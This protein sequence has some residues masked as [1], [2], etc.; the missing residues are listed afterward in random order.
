[1]GCLTIDKLYREALELSFE[2]TDE[3]EEEERLSRLHYKFLRRIVRWSAEYGTIQYGDMRLHT[4]L[5]MQCWSMAVKYK[6]SLQKMKDEEFDDVTVMQEITAEAMIH[7]A[8]AEDTKQII[9]ILKTLDAPT[10]KQLSMGRNGGSACQRDCLFTRAILVFIAVQNLRDANILLK[11]YIALTEA[12]M[13]ALAKSYIN[14]NDGK[15]PTHIMF[16]TM[17]L[18]ICE[19]DR[20]GP[21]YQWILRSFSNDLNL[22]K[23]DVKAYTTK[24]GRV[25]FNIQPPPSMFHMMENM[26]GMMGGAAAMNM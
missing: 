8:L 10:D 1:V 16:C 15:A 14:K 13:P 2:G 17:L 18:Q 3:Q 25:Y 9:D 20:A 4:A 12:D 11:E 5:A 26:M 21:L 23:P 6:S 24:I 7:L 22:M 19:K